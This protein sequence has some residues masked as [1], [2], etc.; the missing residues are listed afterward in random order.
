MSKVTILTNLF[1]MM[2]VVGIGGGVILIIKDIISKIM[3]SRAIRNIPDFDTQIFDAFETGHAIA[4]DA[5]RNQIAI[6]D[7]KGKIDRLDFDDIIGAE[8]VSNGETLIK[9]NRGSQ[10]AGA[11]VGGL[12]FGATGALVGGL[13]GSQRMQEKIR[14]LSIKLYTTDLHRPVREVVAYEGHLI[15][16]YLHEFRM[17]KLDNWYGRLQVIVHSRDLGPP[18]TGPGALQTTYSLRRR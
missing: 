2:L 14:K 10:I 7:R 5:T 13:T 9:T 17:E 1:V 15:S 18:R 12:L 3:A 4:I 11:T 6:R 8:L 16:A